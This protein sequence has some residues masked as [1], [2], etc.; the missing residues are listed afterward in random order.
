MSPAELGRIAEKTGSLRAL[1]KMSGVP[2]RTLQDY[3][4]GLSG[5]PAP[6]AQAVRE[7]HKRDREIMAEVL[8]GVFARI[9]RDFPNGITSAPVET[10]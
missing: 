8:Q 10:E 7:A 1:S 9:D 5:I 4:R 6:V 2:Y 3:K